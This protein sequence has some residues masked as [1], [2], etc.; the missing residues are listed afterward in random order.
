MKEKPHIC[1]CKEYF[2]ILG[3]KKKKDQRKVESFYLFQKFLLDQVEIDFSFE[4]NMTQD[5]IQYYF[6]PT[7]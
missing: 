4:E 5:V 2:T 3:K 6:S 1:K 7:K